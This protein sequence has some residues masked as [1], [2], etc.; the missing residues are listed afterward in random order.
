[1]DQS[2]QIR[3][4][5]FDRVFSVA[6]AAA[7]DPKFRVEDLQ[8]QIA[9]LEAENRRLIQEHE[10]MLAVARADGFDAG[11][12][13]AHAERQAAILAA[14]DALGAQVEVIGAGIDEIASAA[15][16]DA[17]QLALAAAEHI[18]ARALDEV[19]GAAIDQAIGRVLKQVVRGTELLV[20][21]HPDLLPMIEE[22]IGTRQKN[23]RRHLN[24]HVVADSELSPGDARI[25][26]DQGGLMLDA[27]S[28]R[29]AVRA[30]LD[31]LL[32]L[33]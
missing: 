14:V 1:M 23:D 18:A 7:Q 4:F 12:S 20:R 26:W 8:L 6:A 15:T 10:A 32:N 3:P 29:E 25:E 17:A 16:R 13:Q 28:R 5:A 21:V 30:E 19:P 31:Q 11:L 9:A 2:F 22:L 27:A 33:S 24:L